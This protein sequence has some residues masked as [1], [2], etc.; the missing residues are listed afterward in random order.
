MAPLSS[1]LAFDS[2]PLPQ[3]IIALLLVKTKPS[4]TPVKGQ[5]TLKDL[6]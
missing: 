6:V 4:T 5:S 3:L 1:S 2:L